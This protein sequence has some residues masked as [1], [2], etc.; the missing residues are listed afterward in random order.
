MTRSNIQKFSLFFVASYGVFFLWNIWRSLS[1]KLFIARFCWNA[2]RCSKFW[3]GKELE[4]GDWNQGGRI[5]ASIVHRPAVRLRPVM[6]ATVKENG[7]G[8]LVPWEALCQHLERQAGYGPQS[9]KLKMTKSFHHP[10]KC[11]R[12]LKGSR[13]QGTTPWECYY[14]GWTHEGL[15]IWCLIRTIIKWLFQRNLR[16][17]KSSWYLLSNMPLW[18]PTGARTSPLLSQAGWPPAAPSPAESL[19]DPLPKRHQSQTACSCRSPLNPGKEKT[20]VAWM[21]WCGASYIINSIRASWNE[22]F[23]FAQNL[24]HTLCAFLHKCRCRIQLSIWV[25]RKVAML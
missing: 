22:F 18:N 9:L 5:E 24:M 13:S 1:A 7:A 12:K 23:S 8:K 15:A 2:N 4:V 11:K 25:I 14:Q 20:R 10:T 16:Q 6:K 17:G 19:P 3:T 21:R